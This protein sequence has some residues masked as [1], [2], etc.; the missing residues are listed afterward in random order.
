LFN[1]EEKENSLEIIAP[2]FKTNRK[3]WIER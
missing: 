1:V 3:S 2:N